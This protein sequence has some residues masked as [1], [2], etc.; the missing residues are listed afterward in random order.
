ME[1]CVLYSTRFANLDVL[2]EVFH[3]SVV[4]FVRG[5]LA[6]VHSDFSGEPHT[7]QG[8]LGEVLDFFDILLADLLAFFPVIDVVACDSGGDGQEN[9]PVARRQPWTFVKPR[10]W[11]TS[12]LQHCPYTRLWLL[13]L[14]K[15]A[16]SAIRAHCTELER[17]SLVERVKSSVR[18]QEH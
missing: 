17:R 1:M 6:A 14:R 5:P 2:A 16:V 4:L 18:G 12:I 15:Q 11:N 13:R 7:V 8:Y 10:G 3:A 9:E